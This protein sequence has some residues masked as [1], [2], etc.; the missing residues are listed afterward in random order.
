MAF[1]CLMD[2]DGFSM[3]QC[4]VWPLRLED[5]LSGFLAP[6]LFFDRIRNEDH[7]A[8]I[9]YAR[10]NDSFESWNSMKIILTTTQDQNHGNDVG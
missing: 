9:A 5:E 10:S 8:G 4:F 7:E 3:R 1:M 2:L 6:D